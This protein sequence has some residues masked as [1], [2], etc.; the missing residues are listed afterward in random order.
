MSKEIGPREKAAREAREAAYV[1]N[2]K[3]MRA[4]A[5]DGTLEVEKAL[6]AAVPAL[7]NLKSALA[8]AS[9][10]RGKPRKAKKR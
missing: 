8:V 4:M 5:K 10:K 7:E 1:E 3:R 6:R 2:Q 9:L